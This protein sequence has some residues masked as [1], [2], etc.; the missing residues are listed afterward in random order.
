ME[1][2]IAQHLDD[3]IAV[4]KRARKLRDLITARLKAETQ[5]QYAANSAEYRVQLERSKTQ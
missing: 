2:L 4:G 3:A 1:E 5:A